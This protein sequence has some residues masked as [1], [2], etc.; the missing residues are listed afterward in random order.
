MDLMYQYICESAETLRDIQNKKETIFC[1][2]HRKCNNVK[3]DQVILLG[4]GT[5]YNA[6]V[7]ARDAIQTILQVP[8][9]VYYPGEFTDHISL[10]S[11]KGMAIGISQAGRSSST[12]EALQKAGAAGLTTIC[13]TADGNAPIVENCDICIPLLIGEENVGPKT[14]GFFGSV[15]EIILLALEV[16]RLPS[17]ATEERMFSVTDQLKDIAEKAY[18]WYR[19]IKN[20]VIDSTRIIVLGYEACTGA[21]QEGALKLLEGMECSVSGYEMEEFMH[22]IYHAIDENTYIFALGM[23]G[24]HRDR[25][26]RL[27]RY[28]QERKKAHIFV[29]SDSQTEFETFVYPF[30][31][32][33]LFSTMEYIVPLQVLARKLSFDQGKDCCVSSDP[34]FH[35]I[36]ESYRY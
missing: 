12:I 14:K 27:L 28:L 18:D 20:K 32:D 6:A 5:S 23:P 17:S 2:F 16:A 35:K 24:R 33:S 31:N 30:K 19:K 10:F 34:D 13:I 1:D 15:A 22:G 26:Y 25:L 36:M 29:I 11:N 4:S 21:V 3:P 8:V 9:Y 7:T